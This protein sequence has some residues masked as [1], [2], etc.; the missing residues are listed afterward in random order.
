MK[1]VTEVLRD[2]HCLI[3]RAA[4]CLDRVADEVLATDDLRVVVA[5]DL[6]E[7][8]EDF[9][10][11]AH[12]EKEERHLFPALLRLGLAKHRVFELLDDHENEREAL[13]SMWRNLEGA[14][15]GD[16]LSLDDFVRFAVEYAADQRRHADKENHVLL[17][18]VEELMDADTERRV[19]AGFREIDSKLPRKTRAHYVA[20]VQR[21]ARRLGSQIAPRGVT[22]AR[23]GAA[24]GGY[25]PSATLRPR[26]SSRGARS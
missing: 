8:F 15:C 18:L 3:A 25:R 14:A 16:P 9:A 7:F 5:L 4:A 19:L 22:S 13:R 6:L 26:G 24:R 1:K 11:G 21:A 10:D 12:Q 17:P 2:E 23:R 20:L